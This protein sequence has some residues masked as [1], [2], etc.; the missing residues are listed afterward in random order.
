M[1]FL[2]QY[3]VWIFENNRWEL[4]A[5]FFDQDTASAVAQSRKARVKLI[6]AKYED[7][8]PVS[9]ELIAEIGNIRNE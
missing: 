5:A 1:S 3:E 2:E 7:G 8:Q 9:Q 4:I 6:H